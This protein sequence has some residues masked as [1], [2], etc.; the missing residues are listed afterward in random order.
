VPALEGPAFSERTNPTL[1][2]SD[3]EMRRRERANLVAAI[4]RC[5]GKIYGS[6]GAAALLGMKPTTLASRLKKLGIGH[7]A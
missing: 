2:V 6:D 5:R 1:V 7:R 3:A 4:D